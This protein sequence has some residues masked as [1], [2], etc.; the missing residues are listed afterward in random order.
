MNAGSG[1]A[2]LDAESKLFLEKRNTAPLPSEPTGNEPALQLLLLPQEKA[3]PPYSKEATYLSS[4][5]CQ[6]CFHSF[7]TPLAV[8]S[9]ARTAEDEGDNAEA[10]S[11]LSEEACNIE[12]LK[13]LATHGLHSIQECRKEVFSCVIGCPLEPVTNQVLR[14]R[15]SEY[16]AAQCDR[17]LREDP[18]AVCGCYVSL[19][20]LSTVEMPQRDAAVVPEWLVAVGAAE[21]F[22]IEDWFDGMDK[23][24]NTDS[25]LQTYFDPAGKLLQA[26]AELATAQEPA[27]GDEP[28]SEALDKVKELER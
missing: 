9:K 12:V 15:L 4:N 5:P 17:L 25:Y 7:P 23:L 6:L 28:D 1:D 20:Q 21:A 22:S 3:L 10:G 18:C 2:E 26:E 19:S 13:H 8:S 27:Q 16:K 24:F 11:G 14:S